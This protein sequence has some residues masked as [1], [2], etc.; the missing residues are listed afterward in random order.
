MK[1]NGRTVINATLFNVPSED[2]EYV[3]LRR[4]MV[5]DLTAD[6][7]DQPK[8]VLRAMLEEHIMQM[9]EG[10]DDDSLQEHYDS[11]KEAGR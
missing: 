7:L 5:I 9:F 4:Q 6:E 3:E 11:L 8:N 2:D 10:M 1:I